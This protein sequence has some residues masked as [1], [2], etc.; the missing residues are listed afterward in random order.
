MIRH[1]VMRERGIRYDES[2]VCSQDYRLAFDLM[3]AGRIG[4]IPQCLLYYRVSPGQ[5]SEKHGAKQEEQSRIVRRKLIDRYY[6]RYAIPE[7][8]R[9]VTLRT[10]WRNEWELQRI[11]SLDTLAE[12]EKREVAVAMNC[13]RRLLYYSL[14]R[15]S[16]DSLWHFLRSGDYVKCPYKARRFFIILIK[17][18]LPDIVPKLV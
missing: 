16:S 15:Y 7:L 5:V 6:K 2:F 11:L 10:I 12:S 4:N 9:E 13:I 8:D 14:A 1:G 17:H 18:I 3:E